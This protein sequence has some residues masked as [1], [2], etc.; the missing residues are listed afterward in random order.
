MRINAPSERIQFNSNQPLRALKIIYF[1]SPDPD[2]LQDAYLHGLRRLFGASVV[3]YPKKEVMYKGWNA[4]PHVQMYGK[5]FTIWRTLD[6]APVD[7]TDIDNRMW[8]GDYD[9]VI[10]GSIERTLA[11]YNF[12]LPHLDFK[13]TILLDGEDSRG[14]NPR[15]ARKFLYFKRELQSKASYYYN[16]KLVPKFVYKRVS[17][18]RN[19]LPISFAIPKEKILE[20]AEPPPKTKLFPSHIVDA[21][22]RECD[23]VKAFAKNADDKAHVFDD[24]RDYYDDLRQ[25]KFGITTKR[26]GW[27]CLRHY[28]IAANGAVICFRNLRDKEP[29]NAPHGLNETNCIEYASAI[30]LL[31]RIEKLSDATYRSLLS[32]GYKWVLSQTTE[33]KAAD[34]LERAF[35]F[36]KRYA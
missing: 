13:K 2:N 21:E 26:G 17:L 4:R 8:K 11:F 31:E 28:E 14:F 23:K 30:E 22:L 20:S 5:L 35:N 10:F 6:D 33:V 3:D 18:H 9:L 32:E 27:D 16:Y 29:L 36:W 15:Y 19:V 34:M 12:Y 7:R 1:T 24:E 25:S